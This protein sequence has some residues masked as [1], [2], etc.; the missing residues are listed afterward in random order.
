MFYDYGTL[1]TYPPD[2]IH[3]LH[4]KFSYLPAQAIPCGLV[5][6]R[7][8]KAAKWTRSATHHFAMR[9]Q[10][11]LIATIASVNTEVKICI[12]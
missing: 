7:P 12:K 10:M 4:R 6:T 8:H 3:Y 9:T 5:N 1:K 2:A 11:P